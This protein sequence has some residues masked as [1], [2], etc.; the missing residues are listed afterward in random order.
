M[1]LEAASRPVDFDAVPVEF[2]GA[3]GGAFEN[4]IG[5]G[6]GIGRG[7]GGGFFVDGGLGRLS[8]WNST[9]A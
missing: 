7:K 1:R 6:G 8:F 9:T 3:G 2:V 4:V 5:T